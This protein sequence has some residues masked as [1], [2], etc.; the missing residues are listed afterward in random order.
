MIHPDV[1][2]GDKPNL[3]VSPD[4]QDVYVQFNGP[5]A[6]TRTRRCRTTAAITWSTTKVTDS[7]RYYFDYGGAVLPDGR[8]V[9][10]QVSFS[11]TGPD[12]AAEGVQKVHV[13]ASDDDGIT[14]SE[15]VVDELELGTR[16]HVAVVLR[17]LLR[18]RTVA[19]RRSTTAIS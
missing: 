15:L 12:H 3:A 10:G 18:Q 11:Y 19:R 6:A 2:W 14:W 5:T 17:R 16:V 1:K 8:I 9:F 4:G 7:D 13:F